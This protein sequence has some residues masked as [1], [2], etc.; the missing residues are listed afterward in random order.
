MTH[1][2]GRVVGTLLAAQGGEDG[3]PDLDWVSFRAEVDEPGAVRK[4]GDGARGFQ[5][6]AGL[7]APT[8]TRHGH[9]PFARKQGLQLLELD[10]S[11]DERCQGQGQVPG[12][13]SAHV[14]RR[15]LRQDVRLQ[16]SELG[17]RVEAEVVEQPP[18][19]ALIGGEGVG[20]AP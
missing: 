15:V 7:A 18:S 2:V 17:G 13:S 11:T 20:L 12:A 16:L 6:K 10:L 9:E 5:R 19:E 3:A 8:D 4:A 14:E 1:R